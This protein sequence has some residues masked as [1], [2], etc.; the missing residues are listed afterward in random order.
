M[1]RLLVVPLLA[2]AWSCASIPGAAGVEPPSDPTRVLLAR[3]IRAVNV[4]N[5]Y[6]AIQLLRP[7]FFYGRGPGAV[8]LYV[9]DVPVSDPRF[10]EDIP[11]SSISEVELLPGPAATAR[12][13]PA[14][15]TD[16][17][18]VVRTLLRPR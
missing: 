14:R 3:E 7:R 18:L 4:R 13:G 12:Y 8:A 2:C 1:N 17:V 9:D 15:G 11:A 16:G 6:E 10:L 5:A